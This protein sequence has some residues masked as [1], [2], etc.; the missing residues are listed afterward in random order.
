MDII[1]VIK[2]RKGEN[3]FV[4]LLL[5]FDEVGEGRIL[6]DLLQNYCII[7]QQY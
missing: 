2:P 4:V 6:L 3:I 5:L 7:W 1:F